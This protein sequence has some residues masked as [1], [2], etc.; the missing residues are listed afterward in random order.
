MLT[1]ERIKKNTVIQKLQADSKC[2]EFTQAVKILECHYA[3]H[4]TTESVNVY[5]LININTPPHLE[6]IRFCAAQKLVFPESDISTIKQIKAGKSNKWEISVN[7][8]GITGPSGILPYHY[9]E[10]VNERSKK[11]DYA[12]Q[13]F[14]DYF[15]HRTISLFYQ[16]SVKYHYPVQFERSNSHLADIKDDFTNALLSLSGLGTDKNK[17]RLHISDLTVAYYSGL[18]SQTLRTKTGLKSILSDFFGVRVEI[19]EF[20]GGWCR[21]IDDALTRLPEK[22]NKKGHNTE[23]GKTA[24][25]GQFAS[26]PQSKFSIHIGP[27]PFDKIDEFSPASINIKQLKELTQLYI[28]PEYRFDISLRVIFPN[29]PEPVQ[30]NKDNNL[31][32]GWNSWLMNKSNTS[33]DKPR[34]YILK[35][36]N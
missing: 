36:K 3:H 16:A 21:L 1:T 31:T 33:S 30:F 5:D 17:N 28:G 27:I 11:K 4:F 18:F 25:L 13:T 24:L 9:S 22:F 32:L 12:L 23:L 10:L 15:N 26:I 19:D 8:I 34:E 20:T 6:P 29:K 2:F 7:F 35:I 14:F